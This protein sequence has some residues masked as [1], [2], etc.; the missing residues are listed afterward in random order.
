M[1]EKQKT[2]E[3]VKLRIVAIILA[4]RGKFKGGKINKRDRWYG[5]EGKKDFDI[6]KRYWHRRG[7]KEF[8]GRDFENRQE[9]EEA[10]K[11]WESIDRPNI[12]KLPTDGGC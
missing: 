12:R 9:A 7:K 8:G 6:F 1:P 2:R 11:G 3:Q 10:Y 5:L 4:A